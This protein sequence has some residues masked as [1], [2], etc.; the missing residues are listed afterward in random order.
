MADLIFMTCPRHNIR[1]L[2]GNRCSAC[3]EEVK[4]R[5]KRFISSEKMYVEDINNGTK[6]IE[7][8]LRALYEQDGRDMDR[9]IRWVSESM[10]YKN[11]IIAQQ[12]E[13]IIGFHRAARKDAENDSQTEENSDPTSPT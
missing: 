5:G 10:F 4:N 11:H 7:N 3:V 9:F 1:Y 13:I 12:S 8:S 2:K 6:R